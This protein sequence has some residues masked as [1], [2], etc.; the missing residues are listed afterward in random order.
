MTQLYQ[1]PTTD[2]VEQATQNRIAETLRQAFFS[3]SGFEPSPSEMRS[4]RNSLRALANAV[5]S[6]RLDDHG[7]LLEFQLPMSSRRIDALITGHGHE[8]RPSAVIVELKQ[9][10][11]VEPSDV[12]ECVGVRYGGRIRDALHPS[13]QAGS[14]RQYLADSHA[15]FTE[16]G[17]RLDAC[18]F[19]H[20]F[21]FDEQSEL[22]ADRHRD[23]LGV[24]PLFAGDRVSDLVDFLS[25]RLGGGGGMAVLPVVRDGRYRP[26]KKLLDHTA[27]MVKG[28]PAYV[29]LDEQRVV[30]NAI[31]ARVHEARELDQKSVFVIRGGPGT[32]KSVIALNLLAEL[33]AAGFV[34][35]HATGSSAFT[36]TVRKL[37]GWRAAQQFNYFNSYLNAEEDELDVLICDEAHRIR[38]HS[39][40]RFT[41]RRAHYPDRPQIDE[42]LAVA[43]VG[44][45]FI[46]DLQAVRRDEIGNSD[47]IE[48]TALERDAEVH[49]YRLD[50]QFRCGG[51][52]GFVRWIENSLGI[53]RTANALWDGD[54]NFDFEI[55]DAPQQLDA[56]IRQ[57]QDEGASARL[58]A[59]YCW[60]W[61]NPTDD[62]N[63]V[64]DVRIGDWERP[65][66]ARPDA[67][68]LA[69]GIPKSH[70]WA[71]EAGGVDQVGCIY[72]A[73]GFEFDYVGVIFG[74]DLVHRPRR[75]WIGRPEFSKDG[76]MK[77]GTSPERF[78]E[79]VKNTY[80]VL[81]SR[82][83]KGCYVHFTDESTRTFVESRIDTFMPADLA[84]ESEPS[85][86]V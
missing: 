76:G 77:R 81:L 29:L 85:Y 50:V 71:S 21:I 4:W 3:Y 17:L 13:A 36:S 25:D 24:Y 84:A 49:E 55:V 33:S 70:L 11:D 82:G 35:H 48:R 80:R 1:G 28:E 5:S 37:V 43:R 66:N 2:F 51:S 15:A 86:G 79:L 32:G 14:Y 59:G 27:K 61:S 53:R 26:H 39:W 58:V 72:T 10:D 74:D 41:K 54:P 34:T 78:T 42:L 57:R 20:D 47:D 40:N 73:Q 7:I 16:E 30:F 62:G 69:P 67:G 60:P 9:W 65:W 56:L 46:D 8:G 38:K 12:P 44:V 68:R 18:A 31:L 6:A 19:L 83:L 23:L 63:L 64:N 75:G 45:F 52:D 22:L